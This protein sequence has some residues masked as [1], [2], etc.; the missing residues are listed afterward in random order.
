[1]R[2]ISEQSER[3]VQFTSRSFPAFNDRRRTQKIEGCEKST[4][5]PGTGG[6]RLPYETDG[7][8]CGNLF[9][10]GVFPKGLQYDIACWKSLCKVKTCHTL[11]FGN[12]FLHT[13][14]EDVVRVAFHMILD[15]EIRLI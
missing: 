12:I 10:M 9:H 5:T 6:T 8:A 7:D 14:L 1:M 2:E 4:S 3:V 15:V 13:T 11:M